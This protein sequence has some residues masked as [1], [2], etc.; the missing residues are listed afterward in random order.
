MSQIYHP[1]ILFHTWWSLSGTALFIWS[2]RHVL[3]P[4]GL[5]LIS[6]CTHLHTALHFPWPTFPAVILWDEWKKA[7][8]DEF[9]LEYTVNGYFQQ[10]LMCCCGLK[11]FVI[12][13]NGKTALFSWKKKCVLNA[14]VLLLWI[15]CVW[16][17]GL[18]SLVNLLFC[19]LQL[20]QLV[21]DAAKEKR[22]M[23]QKH[24]TIQQK[25]YSHIMLPSSPAPSSQDS[26]P[27]MHLCT[28]II[29]CIIVNVKYQNF[30]NLL[31]SRHPEKDTLKTHTQLLSVCANLYDPSDPQHS[32]GISSSAPWPGSSQSPWSASLLFS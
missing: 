13:Q 8:C 32:G 28:N 31:S 29:I 6:V 5:L 11:S 16:P 19:F 14:G 9:C 3:S 18:V 10:C 21:V 1:P 25:V 27:T 15:K 12:T 2:R 30:I 24:S 23:E 17:G 4:C 22:D 20:D 7:E 26:I